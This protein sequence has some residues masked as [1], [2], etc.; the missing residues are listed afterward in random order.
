MIKDLLQRRFILLHVTANNWEEAIEKAAQ[1]LLLAHMFTKSYVD[2]IIRGVREVGPYFVLA[3]HVALAHARPDSGALENAMG[4]A[5]LE[6]PVNFGSE[7]NDPVKYVFTLSATDN[8][9]HI[10]A[11]AELAEHLSDVKFFDFLS[12]VQDAREVLNYFDK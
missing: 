3:P 1:P 2:D 7:A 6:K 12:N 8:N 11:L 10:D 9:G 5:I 4:L